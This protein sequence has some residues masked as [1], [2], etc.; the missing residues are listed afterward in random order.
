[1]GCLRAV[2]GN[3]A[4]LLFVR[5]VIDADPEPATDRINL[6]RG[7]ERMSPDDILEQS[8]FPDATLNR[9]G[10]PIGR[11]VVAMGIVS[12]ADKKGSGSDFPHAI[13]DDANRAL[14]L[15]AFVGNEAIGETEKQHLIRSQPKLR[16]RLSCLLLAE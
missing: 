16:A 10:D 3:G 15:F 13:S 4:A 7:W 11:L 5:L 1:M 6:S 12:P 2:R 8:D 9:T 14:G